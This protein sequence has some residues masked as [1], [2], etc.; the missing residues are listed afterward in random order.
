MDV[1][2]LTAL[3]DFWDVDGC[4]VV[5]FSDVDG[6]SASFAVVRE[7]VLH[8]AGQTS[9]TN[10]TPFGMPSGPGAMSTISLEQWKV[11]GLN[12]L[13]GALVVLPAAW[14]TGL[15]R[16]GILLLPLLPQ[17]QLQPLPPLPPLPPPLLP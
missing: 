5:R 7:H 3:V 2:G 9:F 4:N 14:L 16:D 11:Q 6:L 10:M 13:G 1:D 17:L 12:E 8:V 15:A